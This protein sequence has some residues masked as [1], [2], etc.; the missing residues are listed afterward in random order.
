MSFWKDLNQNLQQRGLLVQPFPYRPFYT[1]GTGM[2][3]GGVGGGGGPSTKSLFG[4]QY[5]HHS[6]KYPQRF[7]L[8]AIV[9]PLGLLVII[10]YVRQ[11]TTVL[12]S[13]PS[14]IQQQQDQRQ[15][16]Q[17]QKQQQSH[18]LM[19]LNAVVVKAAAAGADAVRDDGG[20]M[21]KKEEE[22]PQHIHIHEEQQQEQI[23]LPPQSQEGRLRRASPDQEPNTKQEQD[24][25]EKPPPPE[26]VAFS[27]SSQML[28]EKTNNKEDS[29]STN[30]KPTI[31]LLTTSYG[32]IEVEMRPDLSK[33]SVQY[34][35]DVVQSG[36]CMKCYFYRAENPGILQG[37]VAGPTTIPKNT[38]G[39]L[40]PL[41]D[42]GQPKFSTPNPKDCPKWDP[43]CGCHGPIMT[44]G[45]VGWAGGSFGGPDFFID[46]YEQ[47]ANFWGTQHTNFGFIHDINSLN[48]IQTILESPVK[49]NGGMHMLVDHV[50]FQLSFRLETSS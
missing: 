37:I 29:T 47:P 18:P 21:M 34:I 6:R 11:V 17:Q 19:E 15:Q 1:M 33:E 25:Q 36:E 38:I 40:C 30:T 46:T 24:H 42:N 32:K 9:L 49:K 27:S 45:S 3:M 50:P 8:V 44:K 7:R 43:N 16:I 35:T 26:D 48:V 28:M 22:H 13:N 23:Q 20:M 41:D 5:Y 4:G 10:L 31:V 12:F 14:Y 39:G 2:G